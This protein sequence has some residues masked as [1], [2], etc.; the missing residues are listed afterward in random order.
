MVVIVASL[1]LPFQPQF[2]ITTSKG[3]EAGLNEAKSSKNADTGG[4]NSSE[5]S[6]GVGLKP[7]NPSSAHSL[8]SPFS[9]CADHNI[10]TEE[11]VAIVSSVSCE[12]AKMSGSRSVISSQLFMENLTSNASNSAVG[13]PVNHV[14]NHGNTSVEEFFASGAVNKLKE[15]D[16]SS[17]VYSTVSSPASE[18]LSSGQQLGAGINN[19]DSTAALLKHVNK[20]LLYQSVLAGNLS[21]TALEGNKHITSSTVKSTVITPRSRQLPEVSSSVSGVQK[22]KQPH[23]NLPAMRRLP[24]K[25]S[26]TVP[27]TNTHSSL[28][29]PLKLYDDGDQDLK[30]QNSADSPQPQ[31]SAK[32][33]VVNEHDSDVSIEYDL[34]LD[35]NGKHSNRVPKFGGCSINAKLRAEL[36][37]N[38]RNIFKTA[39]WKIVPSI[40]GNG[41][42]KNALST[43][44]LEKT[45]DQ[46]VLWVG[47]VG[48]PTDSIPREVLNNITGQLSN[49]FHSRSVIVDD[50]T[51]QGAYKNFCKQILWPTLNYQ[52]PDN[53]N[54]KA[55]EDHS[56]HYY[57]SLNQ[58]FADRIVDSYQDGDTIWVHDYHLMLVPGMVRKVLPNAKIGFFLHVSFP[59]SEVF[60]CF[61]QREKI[62]EGILGANSVGFQTEEYA[63][64]FQQTANRLLM[65]DVDSHNLKYKGRIIAVESTPIGVDVFDLEPQVNSER[66]IEWRR[67]IRERWAG[68][69]LIVSRDQFDR[70]R[71]IR[72]K[73]LAY[74]RFLKDNPEYI[75]QVV[76]I[77]ICLGSGYDSELE[78]EIMAVVDRINAMSRDISVSQPVVFLHQ[79]LQFPQYLA[80]SSEADMFLVSTMRE[81]MNLTCHEF[82]VCSQEKNAPLV[83]SEFT[84]SAHVLSPGCFL[85]NPWD[86]RQVAQTIK[87]GLELSKEEKRRR[88]KKM[89]KSVITHD[90]DRWIVSSLNIISSSWEANQERSKVYNLSFAKINN[91]FINSKRRMF[92]LKISEPPTARTLAVLTE[93][94][95]KN[96]VYVLNSLSRSMLE[97]LYSRVPNIGLIAENGAFIRVSGMWYNLVEDVSWKEDIVKVFEDKVERLP[98]SYYKKGETMIKFHT[99][100]AED[101]DRVSNVVGDAITHV[102]TLFGDRGVHAY[103]HKNIVF[104]QQSG[105]AIKA[106]Q[107]TL[108]H[109]ATISDTSD[110]TPLDTPLASPLMSPVAIP[111]IS[112]S[113]TTSSKQ[114]SAATNASYISKSRSSTLVD[115]LSVSGSSSPIIEP[116]FQYVNDLAKRG[117][118]SYCYTI[119]YG[120]AITTYA[121]EHVQGL[122]ELFG[123]L[124]RLA[125]L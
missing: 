11:E 123:T 26:G 88:W 51:F 2:E 55:F 72:K 92:I 111:A 8:T 75:D 45:I 64:H 89:Y 87:V 81:G 18:S 52:I 95:T 108:N 122:N 31:S 54:S 71:G 96:I 25:S 3:E 42:L 100:N 41:G 84:G 94:C 23:I 116:L 27:T 47:T 39:P 109:Y 82:I 10:E 61:A 28:K 4:Q 99:E 76:L 12:A 30:E 69:K 91:G 80:L 79:D 1:F 50:I 73:M 35:D 37:L 115:F 19:V 62:L 6:G 118:I 22:G 9:S 110:S 56:W 68:K 103:V 15:T 14:Y 67:L 98:G 107:F 32:E 120:N 119:A 57:R 17:E 21:T 102:N 78:C 33:P 58:L 70:I 105:L 13:T 24:R 121:K 97:R 16:I 117:E 93:L 59:S 124:G 36:L 48:I 113:S 44:L 29:Y 66:T 20:S 65:A 125:A 46:P 106:I 83:L 74:E 60:K 86:I 38:S 63:R 77:Q 104:V 7:Q 43:A 40:K 53:P 114:S 101:Q 5:P 34:A 49:G 112:S 85:I 90:S